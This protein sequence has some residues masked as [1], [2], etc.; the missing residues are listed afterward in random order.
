MLI[1]SGK[2]VAEKVKNQVAERSI[3]FAKKTGRKP[4]LAVIIV[5]EDPASKVYVANKIKA[6][7][8]AGILSSHVVLPA[9]IS[10][11]LLEEKIQMLN[12]DDA[13]DGIL[14]Q[15]PL[16]KTLNSFQATNKIDPRKDADG[17]T[18]VNQ[19]LLMIGDPR[20]KPCTPAGVIEIL[21][22]Y[23]IPIAGEK[24]LVIGRS[25]IVGKPMAMLLLEENATVTVA[26]SKTKDLAAE[27][28]SASL[29]VVAAGKPK[30]LSARDF[31]RNSVVIDVGIHRTEEGLCGDVDISNG[32][33]HLR[34]ATPVP[35]GVGLMTI[36]CLLGNTLDLA[37]QRCGINTSR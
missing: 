3:R 15:L 14:L 16:P 24:T 18:T 23:D 36:A 9:N 27:L 32:E 28:K 1:L 13:V 19:G 35:G 21:K 4:G 26:H 6:C 11:S 8:Q 7:E 37:D 17:L 29:V 22:H 10:Q 12:D 5:G 25:Q 2:A 31:A 34:A 30:F 33:G 20:V